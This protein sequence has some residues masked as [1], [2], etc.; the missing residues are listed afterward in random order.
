M[1]F[2]N[3]KV[4]TKSNNR[5]LRRAAAV[6]LVLPTR[7]GKFLTDIFE[8]AD[9]LLHGTDDLVRKGYGWVL[10]E[11]SKAHQSEVFS[12]V[13]GNKKGYAENGA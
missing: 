4:W 13:M 8:I 1:L 9:S 7:K 12:Y 2:E 3:L 6:T 10:K 11:A 5:W